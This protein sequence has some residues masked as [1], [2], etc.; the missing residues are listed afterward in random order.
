VFGSDISHILNPETEICLGYTDA[1]CP[2]R[3][4]PLNKRTEDN[5]IETVMLLPDKA[6]SVM[7]ETYAGYELTVLDENATLEHGHI[8]SLQ[9]K[10]KIPITGKYKVYSVVVAE[11]ESSDPEQNTLSFRKIRTGGSVT[12]VNEFDIACVEAM[13]AYIEQEYES[14]TVT[15]YPMMSD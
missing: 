5:D 4:E 9:I 14:I 6:L 1:V 8:E 3:K 15:S 13:A 10:G 7:T 11:F 2:R 12:S